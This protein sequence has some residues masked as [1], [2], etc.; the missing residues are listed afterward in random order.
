ML[1]KQKLVGSK[2]KDHLPNLT[3][4]CSLLQESKK[5]RI[6]IILMKFFILHEKM[7]IFQLMQEEV[8]TVYMKL[9]SGLKLALTKSVKERQYMYAT[10]WKKIHIHFKLGTVAAGYLRNDTSY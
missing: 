3:L 4:S 7:Q 9:I 5:P 1:S 8:K 10:V 6:Q 2:P